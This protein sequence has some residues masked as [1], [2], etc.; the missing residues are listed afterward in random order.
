MGLVQVIVIILGI[1]VAIVL[2]LIGR[3]ASEVDGTAV[4]TSGGHGWICNYSTIVLAGGSRY[5][6]LRVYPNTGLVAE[7]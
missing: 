6:T 2:P 4:G 1:I 5:V 3:G 7:S